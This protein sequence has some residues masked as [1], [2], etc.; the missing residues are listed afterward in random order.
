[1]VMVEVEE[2]EDWDANDEEELERCALLRGMNMRLTSSLIELRPF[3]A[4]PLGLHPVLAI[5]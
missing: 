3:G 4:P 5:G 2:P 1:M